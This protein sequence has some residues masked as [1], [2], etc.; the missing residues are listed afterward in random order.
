VRLSSALYRKS[1]RVADLAEHCGVS[2]A[3]ANAFCW[4]MRASGALRLDDGT[5]SPGCISPSASSA[6]I[7]TGFI[8]KRGVNV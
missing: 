3:V 6:C 5:E 8:P 7:A 2:V 1:W 4:A